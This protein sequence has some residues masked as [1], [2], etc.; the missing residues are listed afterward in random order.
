MNKEQ[1]NNLKALGSGDESRRFVVADKEK[2][3]LKRDVQGA[4]KSFD[5]KRA[6]E[7]VN[8]AEN[9]ANLQLQKAAQAQRA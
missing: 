3:G 5:A 6:F 9:S 7:I 8:M 2:P 4:V 1:E